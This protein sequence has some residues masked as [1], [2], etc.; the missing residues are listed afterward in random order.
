MRAGGP[1]EL[2]CFSHA[3]LLHQLLGLDFKDLKSGE[4]I[5]DKKSN[6]L[7]EKLGK[8]CIFTGAEMFP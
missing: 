2:L 3:L 7:C 5:L 1:C 6:S 4:R 8:C